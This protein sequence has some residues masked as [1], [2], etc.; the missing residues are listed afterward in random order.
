MENL[1]NAFSFNYIIKPVGES[2]NNACVYCYYPQNRTNHVLRTKKMPLRLVEKIIRDIAEY[3]SKNGHDTAEIVWHGGEPLLAGIDFYEEVFAFQKN[4]SVSFRNAFQTNGELI[5]REWCNFFKRNNCN[6][7]FSLDGP[8]EIHNQQRMSKN[9]GKTASKVLRGI[10]LCLENEV[11]IGGILCVVSNMSSGHPD[12]ILNYFY[13]NGIKTFDFLAAHNIDNEKPSNSSHNL[14][15]EKFSVFMKRVFS[16]YLEKDDP[17][18]E[19]R[20]ISN[21]LSSLFGGS[22]SVCHMQGTACGTFLTI[23]QDGKALFCD[24]YNCGSLEEIGDLTKET[25]FHIARKNRFKS[26]RDMAKD[27]LYKCRGCQVLTVCNG[28]CLRDWNERG[29]YFCSYYKDFYYHC[30]MKVMAILQEAGC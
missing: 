15:P 1:G 19:I 26:M 29:S 10:R 5:N 7:G 22:A 17:E 25:I 4:S 20:T 18:V 30:Y 2:C 12:E 28:G 27:R 8:P 14:N 21:V 11:G 23:Y 3:E 13:A 9:G 6:I 24:D 16:W